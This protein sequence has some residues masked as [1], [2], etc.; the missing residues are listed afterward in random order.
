MDF[1]NSTAN[2][3]SATAH[4]KLVQQLLC[5]T[6]DTANDTATVVSRRTVNAK[7]VLRIFSRLKTAQLNEIRSK[8]GW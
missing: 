7:S 5:S 2:N 8:Q 4:Y 3:S 6:S 1:R